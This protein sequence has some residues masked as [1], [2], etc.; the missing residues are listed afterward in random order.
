MARKT[1]ASL[2]RELALAQQ[3]TR[4]SQ[5]H[6]RFFE[7]KFDQAAKDLAKAD[8]DVRWLRQ[9]CVQLTDTLRLVNQR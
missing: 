6:A 2:E 4:D 9:L 3:R 8:G 7:Q 5:E 1:I